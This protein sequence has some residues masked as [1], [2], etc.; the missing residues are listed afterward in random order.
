MNSQDIQD[1]LFGY[2]IAVGITLIGILVVLGVYA[3]V[4]QINNTN[5][6]QKCICE[7]VD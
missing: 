6:Y 4:H 3:T 7:K 1:V 2:F 5:Y